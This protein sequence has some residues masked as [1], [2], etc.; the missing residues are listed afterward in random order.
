MK[1]KS[2]FSLTLILLYGFTNQAF[3][4]EPP[5]KILDATLFS[6]S[7]Q[8]Q[9]N[10]SN[11]LIEKGNQIWL[12]AYGYN[13]EIEMLKSE[14]RFSKAKKV[15]KKQERLFLQASNYFRDGHKGH[16]QTLEKEL[17]ESLKTNG[18][19]VAREGLMDGEGLYKKAR[20]VRMN[21][22]NRSNDKETVT[23]FYDAISLENQS[24]SVMEK[25]FIPTGVSEK[26][27]ADKMAITESLNTGNADLLSFQEKKFIPAIQPPAP[28]IAAPPVLVVPEPVLVK[29][30]LPAPVAMAVNEP[31][32]KPLEKELPGLFF[33]IQIL[34]DKKEAPAAAVSKVYS[35]SL[36]VIHLVGDGWHRYMVGRFRSLPDARQAMT[37][38]SIKGFI[39]AYNGDTRIPVQE[40]V[41]LSKNIQ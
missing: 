23:L 27:L 25:F 39:V 18:S 19:D 41:E 14:F 38:E 33:S 10:K 4:N 13:A 26:L 12:Q 22:Q 34:A 21:A 32:V 5:G 17:R 2:I 11:A 20:K 31:K 9:I 24:I 29:E 35:G 37:D 1:I 7:S 28:V 40:A 36:P 16:Y 30:A 6:A 3:G 8:K 15:S